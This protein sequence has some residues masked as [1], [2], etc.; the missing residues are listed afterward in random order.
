MSFYDYYTN[1]GKPEDLKNRQAKLTDTGRVEYGGGGITPD[2]PF[3]EPK[4]VP[5]ERILL[6]HHSFFD[7]SQTWL[8]SHTF[9]ENGQITPEMIAAFKDQLAKKKI[10][11]NTAEFDPNI[12]WI[13]A[14]LRYELLSS[15]YTVEDGARAL[16]EWD[17]IIRKAVS[18]MPQA[19]ALEDSALR[20][21]Q[22]KQVAHS[23][24]PASM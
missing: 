22:S 11:Y 3:E 1:S 13:K 17:P 19:Q 23:N 15:A 18:I 20:A 21:A 5:I 24:N 16:E 10:G 9:P 12:E 2:V 7:F 8:A 4:V 6:A 14:Q